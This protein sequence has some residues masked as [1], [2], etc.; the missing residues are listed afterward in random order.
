MS[1]YCLVC[2]IPVLEKLQKRRNMAVSAVAFVRQ[3]VSES[4]Y[5]GR[6]VWHKCLY[7]HER[8]LFFAPGWYKIN[9]HVCVAKS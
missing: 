6:H 7:R 8:T 3:F 4:H 9:Q 5:E 2:L 1:I